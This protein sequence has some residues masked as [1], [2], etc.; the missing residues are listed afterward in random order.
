MSALTTELSSLYNLLKPCETAWT[1]WAGALS[2]DAYPSGSG[3]LRSGDNAYDPMGVLAA[4][5]DV[6]WTWDERDEAWAYEGEVYTLPVARI[7]E[8]LGAKGYHVGDRLSQLQTLLQREADNGS[9]LSQLGEALLEG[10]AQ[11]ERE[12]QRF[13]TAR[14][15]RSGVLGMSAEIRDT[16]D[17]Y[18]RGGVRY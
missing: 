11:A 8:W 12:H 4:I 5:N 14:M 6:D 2:S 16:D 3:V 7:E 17:F 13:S 1:M 9:T 10:K 15:S 18:G